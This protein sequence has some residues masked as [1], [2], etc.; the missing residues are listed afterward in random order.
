MSD[1]AA[2]N[3]DE[4]KN[5]YVFLQWKGTDACFDFH[6]ECGAQCHFD[7]YFAY[8]VKC[9]HC[10]AVYQMPFNIFPR[11]VTDTNGSEPKLLEKDDDFSHI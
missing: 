9:P 11:K 1:D 8:Y 2:F 3:Y 7:G 4:K 6:C 10:E 5:P